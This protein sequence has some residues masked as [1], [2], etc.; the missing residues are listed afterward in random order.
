M[1]YSILDYN[2]S[3]AK[4][5][6][7]APINSA[8][9]TVY[10]NSV[11][12]SGVLGAGTGP[13]G[14]GGGTASAGYVNNAPQIPQPQ[15]P[16][17]DFD[18][19]IAPALQ[20]LDAAIQPL[21]DS[22]NADISAIGTQKQQAIDSTNQSIGAQ[23]S[24]IGKAQTT[25]KQYEQSASDSARRQYSEIQ[26]GLQS[27]YGGTTGT[28]AF[29]SELAGTQT[30]RSMADI[31]TNAANA[32]AALSD[33]LLQVEEVGRTAL[34]HIESDTADQVAKAKSNLQLQLADIRNQKGQL[35]AHKAELAANAVQMYQQTVN[36]VNTANAQ[37]KQQLYVQQQAAQQTL[38]QSLQ[39]ATGIAQA[40]SPED[41]MG[42][43]QQ[44]Q[45][46]G[47]SPTVTQKYGGA[48]VSFSPNKNNEDENPFAN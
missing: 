5:G 22:T 17:I 32:Q 18:A 19:L 27:R 46:A 23:K 9:P 29:A 40:A 47:Y 43:V 15:Q 38:Q 30:L 28:G 20:G 36:Q 21:T 35:M 33:K 44:W 13:S 1:A 31:K 37:F 8:P 10:K 45:S 25:Q 14:G 12:Q 34:A 39:K 41:L 11:P 7:S 3:L 6:P 24:T 2:K 4:A 26:Q 16:S 42:Y 48:T